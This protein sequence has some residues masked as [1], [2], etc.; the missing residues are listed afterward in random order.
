VNKLGPWVDFKK[1]EGLYCKSSSVDQYMAGLTRARLDLGRWI[2]IERP[3]LDRVG[4]GGARCRR[5]HCAAAELAG[6]GRNGR[7]GLDS[8][9]V[10]YGKR[11]HIAANST[12]C[13]ARGIGERSRAHD[14]EGRRGRRSLLRRAN[15]GEKEQEREREKDSA[16][17][18]TLARSSGAAQTQRGGGEAAV[19]ERRP[20]SSREVG[21]S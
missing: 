6:V 9:R 10:L 4:S 18:L 14:G 16:T 7:P 15:P 17:C 19:R 21:A 1:T 12:G 11:E 20:S 3:G 2:S 5:R 8:A 13:S